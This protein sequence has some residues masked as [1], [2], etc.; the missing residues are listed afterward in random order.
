MYVSQALEWV[1]VLGLTGIGLNKGRV[2]CIIIARVGCIINARVGYMVSK[3]QVVVC[4][5]CASRNDIDEV[6][7]VID[8]SGGASLMLLSDLSG[9]ASPQTSSTSTS[10]VTLPSA[11]PAGQYRHSTSKCLTAKSA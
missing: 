8:I 7:G 1:M 3:F 5:S 10:V 2:G 6:G 9:F 11:L 4:R